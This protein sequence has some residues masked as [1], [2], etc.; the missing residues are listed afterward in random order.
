MSGLQLKTRQAEKSVSAQHADSRKKDKRPCVHLPHM[1]QTDPRG[2][3][4]LIYSETAVSACSSVSKEHLQPV[5]HTVL[6]SVCVLQIYAY[7]FFQNK[8]DPDRARAR[9]VPAHSPPPCSAAVAG[10][11]GKQMMETRQKKRRV[12]STET[13]LWDDSEEEESSVLREE[14]IAREEEEARMTR[15]KEEERMEE[16]HREEDMRLRKK[17]EEEDT[18]RKLKA[19]RKAADEEKDKRRKLG[20]RGRQINRKKKQRRIKTKKTPNTKEGNSKES[21][22]SIFDDREEEVK[23][24]RSEFH[25]LINDNDNLN[26]I[27]ANM[28]SRK[29]SMKMYENQA[30]MILKDMGRKK[31][32]TTSDID[33]EKK[34]FGAGYERQFE[35]SMESVDDL[36]KVRGLERHDKDTVKKAVLEMK[37]AISNNYE[38]FMK[39]YNRGIKE[40]EEK[41]EKQNSNSQ[42]ER[43][44]SGEQSQALSMDGDW[45]PEPSFMPEKNLDTSNGIT[46]YR[47]WEKNIHD[48]F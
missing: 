37:R 25:R 48:F 4:E 18:S 39:D 43:S 28:D 44:T 19:A 47:R 31:K 2:S 27:V 38:V 24:V 42:N 14:E 20:G 6:S 33:W 15:R 41:E 17:E 32:I 35:K 11:P 23:R 21:K 26:D 3:L 40:L 1:P 22:K 10:I 7:I 46:S 13:G 16:M 12:P 5:H 8:D 45:R 29:Q 34:R 9:A 36:L 30:M